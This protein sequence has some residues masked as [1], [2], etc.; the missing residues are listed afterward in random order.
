MDVWRKICNIPC[1][2]AHVSL[3]T[4]F[5]LIS[6]NSLIHST[7]FYPLLKL[8]DQFKVVLFYQRCMYDNCVL[9]IGFV[10]SV[11]SLKSF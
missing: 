10:V 9:Y 3:G 11:L 8:L 2:V 1:C 5:V 4:N 7:C 6:S